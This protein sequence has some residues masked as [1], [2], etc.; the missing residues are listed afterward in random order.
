VEGEGEGE[1]EGLTEEWKRSRYVGLGGSD[2][3]GYGIAT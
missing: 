1:G 3:M 2:S